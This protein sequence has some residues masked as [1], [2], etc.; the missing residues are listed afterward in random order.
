MG[1]SFRSRRLSQF[2]QG[3][4]WL[5]SLTLSVA[6]ACLAATCPAQFVQGLKIDGTVFGSYDDNVY[7]SPDGQRYR[8]WTTSIEPHLAFLQE[9]G[10]LFL[11]VDYRG[12]G[13]IYLN[14]RPEVDNGQEYHTRNFFSNYL[15]LNLGYQITDR[16]LFRFKDNLDNTNRPDFLMVDEVV[17][18]RFVQNDSTAE[19]TYRTSERLELS[20]GYGFTFTDYYRSDDSSQQDFINS[21]AQMIK[22]AAYYHLSTRT[23]ASVN[24]YWSDRSFPDDGALDYRDNLLTFG[25]DHQLNEQWAMRAEAGVQDRT[26]DSSIWDSGCN[27]YFRA[28]VNLKRERSDAQIAFEQGRSLAPNYSEDFY[29]D[30]ILHGSW[31]WRPSNRDSLRFELGTRWNRF[32]RYPASWTQPADGL[33]NDNYVY[34]QI[35]YERQLRER[36]ILEGNYQYMARNSNNSDFEF[37]KNLLQVGVRFRL[38][39]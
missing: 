12:V 8:T 15:Q 2:R 11:Q 3:R 26:L 21:R 22:L 25:L 31:T 6:L 18:G 27:F 10:R 33:R 38:Y 28:E 5:R 30:Y 20:A 19:L 29:M 23:K 9:G 39:Q 35:G 36:I 34:T 37:G 24:Y 1:S 14:F 16:L 32:E 7:F 13:D 4:H 17:Y